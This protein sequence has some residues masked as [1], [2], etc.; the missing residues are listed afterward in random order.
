VSGG[1]C[2][3]TEM[4]IISI[5]QSINKI[6]HFETMLLTHLTVIL[7]P[8]QETPSHCIFTCHRPPRSLPFLSVVK[9]GHQQSH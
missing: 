7:E 2:E 8:S 1:W 4:E 3:R 5:N 9:K 6:Q